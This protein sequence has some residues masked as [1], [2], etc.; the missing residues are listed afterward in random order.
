LHTGLA[1]KVV[2][3]ELRKFKLRF[4]GGA[5]REVGSVNDD[6]DPELQFG[7]DWER[8][9]FDNTRLYATVDYYPNV[10]AF[11]EF[12][13]NTNAGLDFL[14]DASRNINFRIFAQN[15]YDNTD[16]LKAVQAETRMRKRGTMPTETS[17]SLTHSGYHLSMACAKLSFDRLLIS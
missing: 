8:K 15:R 16:L 5:S 4:G 10:S 9:I 1:F 14:V 3:E 17:P 7:A 2:D 6:W 12:R 13:L 11:S